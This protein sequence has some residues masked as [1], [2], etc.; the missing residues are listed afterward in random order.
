LLPLF[1][2][3]KPGPLGTIAKVVKERK[4][5]PLKT[6]EK[7]AFFRGTRESGPKTRLLGH[8]GSPGMWFALSY[9]PNFTEKKE[10][11]HERAFE[12]AGFRTARQR[13]GETGAAAR[14][15]RIL[16]CCPIGSRKI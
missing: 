10:Q 15:G 4:E 7:C 12:L 8:F 11:E 2:C 3:K 5:K 1:H 14:S 13:S 9:P 6:L 16:G